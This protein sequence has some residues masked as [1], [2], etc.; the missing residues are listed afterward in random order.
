M[1]RPAR[2][3]AEEVAAKYTPEQIS[4]IEREVQLRGA[5]DPEGVRLPDGR[6]VAEARLDQLDAQSLARTGQSIYQAEEPAGEPKGEGE[7]PKTDEG[8]EKEEAAAGG[9]KPAA[10]PA[11]EPATT[12][13]RRP[14]R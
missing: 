6:T 13:R 8:P 12:S 14:A 7:E 2:L 11:A 9:E 4:D 10:E 5:A 1:K 3:S